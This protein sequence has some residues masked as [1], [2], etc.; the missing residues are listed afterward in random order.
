MRDL[1]EVNKGI[2]PAYYIRYTGNMSSL[3]TEAEK[4]RDQGYSYNMISQSLGIPKSTMSYW[5]KDRPFTPNK[6]VIHRIKYGPIK[7]GAQRHNQRVRDIQRLKKVGKDEIGELSSRDLWMLGLGLY[8]GEGSK[9][10]EDIRVSNSDPAVIITAIKW[11]KKACDLT[12]ENINIRLHIYP[13]TDPVEA[14]SYWQSVTGLPLNNFYESYID[15]RENKK[16]GN[17]RKLPYGTAHVRIVSK[18]D[19]NKGVA[20]YR[21]I[22]GWMAGALDQV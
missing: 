19:P 1:I 17:R 15:F 5:F 7:S 14:V 22:S 2:E 9:T 12:E 20:L 3:R 18:G 13:D 16:L 6:K 8:I 4:L 10:T 21:R 11:F